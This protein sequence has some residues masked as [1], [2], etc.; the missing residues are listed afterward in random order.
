[1]STEEL[2]DIIFKLKEWHEGKIEQFNHILNMPEDGTIKFEGKDGETVDLPKED[3]KV[4]KIGIS[5]ALEVL[6]EF[7]VKITKNE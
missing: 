7:P 4:F 2:T 1:M 5:V 3:M 6:G